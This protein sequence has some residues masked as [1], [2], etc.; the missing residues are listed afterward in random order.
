MTLKQM[1]IVEQSRFI[2][3]LRECY[4][5]GMSLL[6]ILGFLM[7]FVPVAALV[8]FIIFVVT[9]QAPWV[10]LVAAYL[11]TAVILSLWRSR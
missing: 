9:M 7:F 2:V 3:R 4:F 8:L 10:V 5:P 1:Q 6:N 11:I